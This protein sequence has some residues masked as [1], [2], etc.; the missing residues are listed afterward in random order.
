MWRR[1]LLASNSIRKNRQLHPWFQSL[2]DS[3]LVMG[4]TSC[5]PEIGVQLSR[6]GWFVESLLSHQDSQNVQETGLNWNEFCRKREVALERRKHRNVYF[7][8][9]NNIKAKSISSFMKTTK[10][11]RWYVNYRIWLS[12]AHHLLT[13]WSRSW[14]RRPP[15]HCIKTIWGTLGWWV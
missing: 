8:L 12:W 9:Q 13:P 7:S 6:F 1:T 14:L 4:R 15:C 11:N 5:E 3:C 2:P 10:E